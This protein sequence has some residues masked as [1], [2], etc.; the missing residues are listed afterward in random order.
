MIIAYGIQAAWTRLSDYQPTATHTEVNLADIADPPCRECRYW[1]PRM[2]TSPDVN[3][4]GIQLCALPEGRDQERDFSCFR[5][6]ATDPVVEE[7]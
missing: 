3:L 5:P 7:R 1:A 2:V 6:M 4:H